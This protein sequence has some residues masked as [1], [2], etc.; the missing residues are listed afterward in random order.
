VCLSP[1]KFADA[2]SINF[3][4]NTLYNPSM[5]PDMPLGSISTFLTKR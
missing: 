5:H 2:K 3:D 1:A 4:I